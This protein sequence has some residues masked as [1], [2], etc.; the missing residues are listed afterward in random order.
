MKDLFKLN[1]YDLNDVAR[2]RGHEK[3]LY[4]AGERKKI[5]EKLD[6]IDRRLSALEHPEAKPDGREW[7]MGDTEFWVMLPSREILKAKL[8]NL[9]IP[10]IMP[11]IPG[12]KKPEPPEVK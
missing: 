9:S 12:D 10:A 5:L 1:P 3:E 7:I 6:E 4:E 8:I 2:T 11:Y